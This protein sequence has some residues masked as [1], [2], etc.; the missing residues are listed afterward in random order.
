MVMV[1]CGGVDMSIP[2]TNGH[3]HATQRNATHDEP[4]SAREP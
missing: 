2:R 1:W 3:E 4:R